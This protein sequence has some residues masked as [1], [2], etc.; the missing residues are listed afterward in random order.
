M[1]EGKEVRYK[2]T[3]TLSYAY[4]HSHRSH[5]HTPVKPHT[6]TQRRTVNRTYAVVRQM[7][8]IGDCKAQH[9]SRMRHIGTIHNVNRITVRCNIKT[10]LSTDNDART[11]C[12]S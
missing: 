1:F 10:L 8:G 2:S 6:R 3:H 4:V 9:S 12:C 11:A 5:E 7:S